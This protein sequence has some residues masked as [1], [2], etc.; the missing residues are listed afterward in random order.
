MALYEIYRREANTDLGKKVME[1]DKNAVYQDAFGAMYLSI[2]G[3]EEFV[4]TML[5]CC[6]ILDYYEG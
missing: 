6:T 1:Y 4:R 2:L 5:A 3:G